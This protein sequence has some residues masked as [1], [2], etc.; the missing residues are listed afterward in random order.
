M[1]KQIFVVNGYPGSGKT[2][3]EKMVSELV[4]TICYSSID[5]IRDALPVPK[6]KSV[7]YRNYLALGKQV[8]KEYV[9]TKISDKFWEFIVDPE[10]KLLFIDCRE[11]EEIDWLVKH[12]D[13]HTLLVDRP[14]IEPDENLSDADMYVKNY[15]YEVTIHNS[16]DLDQL[17]LA[18]KAFCSQWG[19]I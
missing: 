13:A 9:R 15:V 3:F 18:A 1:K 8:F 2:E 7:E 5:P 4:P 19:Y 17:R 11:P 12:C 10:A 14:G 16:G 6:E